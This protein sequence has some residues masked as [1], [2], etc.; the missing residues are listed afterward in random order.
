MEEVNLIVKLESHQTIKL[1]LNLFQHVIKPDYYKINKY[2][3]TLHYIIQSPNWVCK[4]YRA[5]T[6]NWSI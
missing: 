5:T 6:K 2:Y 3:F 1:K 4:S